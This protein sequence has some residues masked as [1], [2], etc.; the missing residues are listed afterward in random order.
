MVERKP[1]ITTPAE[2]KAVPNPMTAAPAAMIPAAT[3]A[4]ILTARW[5]F[6]IHWISVVSTPAMAAMIRCSG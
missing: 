6:S 2:A 5:F 3:A 4:A 1:L